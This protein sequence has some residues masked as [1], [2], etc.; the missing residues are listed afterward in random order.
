MI[1]A[2]ATGHYGAFACQQGWVNHF[3]DLLA[4]S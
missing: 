2:G 3:W 4:G 1:L